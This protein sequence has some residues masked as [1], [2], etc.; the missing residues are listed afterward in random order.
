MAVRSKSNISG[1]TRPRARPGSAGRFSPPPRRPP[2]PPPPP[3]APGDRRRPR[4]SRTC[5][6]LV[7]TKLP[8]SSSSFSLNLLYISR[9]YEKQNSKDKKDPPGNPPESSGPDSWPVQGSSTLRSDGA[10]SSD[11]KFISEINS[12]P[13]REEE[14]SE[15]PASLVGKFG[16]SA[17]GDVEEKYYHID[18][19]AN[20]LVRLTIEIHQTLDKRSQ[21]MRELEKVKDRLNF[22]H[23]PASTDML[24]TE[25]F[26]KDTQDRYR[27]LLSRVKAIDEIL[28][29]LNRQYDDTSVL[30]TQE[31]STFISSIKGEAE[32]SRTVPA[33]VPSKPLDLSTFE[34]ETLKSR[35]TWS[36]VKQSNYNL[37]TIEPIQHLPKSF[38]SLPKSRPKKHK[39]S[40]YYYG[41]SKYLSVPTKLMGP[42]RTAYID[43]KEADMKELADIF[44]NE[45]SR[46]SVQKNYPWFDSN[47]TKFILTSIEDFKKLLK[48][49]DDLEQA[50][51]W[52]QREI[53]EIFFGLGKISTLSFNF[54]VAKLLI[55]RKLIRITNDFYSLEAIPALDLQL[56]TMSALHPCFTNI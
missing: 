34:P 38:G 31:I 18:K 23:R 26:L 53:S 1:G 30:A 27:S 32:D 9:S 3:P 48:W 52:N 10:V 37:P 50:E 22:L 7:V 46:K 11:V 36:S 17:D 14:D 54:F 41:E 16:S 19:L 4:G 5:Y 15:K 21:M 56:I 47:A 2:W 43:D 42:T 49:L 39:G 24:V 8:P 6:F 44:G 12:F 45:N 40:E 33:I 51:K 29:L 13:S 28:S 35:D 55:N 25:T 20:E